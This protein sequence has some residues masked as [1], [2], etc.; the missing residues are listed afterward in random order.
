[1][2]DAFARS[3]V[4]VFAPGPRLT[5][6]VEQGSDADQ[7]QP[8]LH[9]G[10]QGFWVARM[11]RALG[12]RVTIC[13]PLGGETG[14]VVRGL[15]DGDD[16]LDAKV[17]ETAGPTAM[18]VH[19]RRGGERKELLSTP[20]PYLG[21]HEFDELYT[22]MLGAA[23][24]SDIAVVTGT[25]DP[26]AVPDGSFARLVTDVHA[27][28]APVVAD[29]SGT[30]LL[31]AV[32]GGPDLVKVST[33]ELA[34]CGLIIE[35]TPNEIVDAITYLQQRG[36]GDLV[37]T[38]AELP[39]VA[40]LGENLYEISTPHLSVVDHRGAGDSLTGAVAA[41][42]AAGLPVEEA[43]RLGAAAG[44]LNVT[45]HGLATGTRDTIE[46]LATRVTL[47]PLHRAAKERTEAVGT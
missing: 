22:A 33:E 44:A 28:G 46:Q 26:A 9:P 6:T 32:E 20:E 30:Q 29:L 34:A 16:R 21:R 31:D 1:M 5:V 41:A 15:L 13:V 4:A 36:A 8:H 27:G 35:D 18:Y 23:L 37:I 38:R 2:A 47:A 43:V 42:L 39:A 7:P 12:C 24:D 25:V 19:D 17:A 10:G 40:M 14:S 45:R 3:A 11:A